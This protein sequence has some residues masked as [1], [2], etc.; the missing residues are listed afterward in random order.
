MNANNSGTNTNNAGTIS[1]TNAAGTGSITQ[2]FLLHPYSENVNPSAVEG[3]KLYLAATKELDE[4]KR[5][6]V[7]IENG[8]KVKNHLET[9]SS[10]CS[11]GF[12]ISKAPDSNRDTKDTIKNYKSITMDD[13][14]A[15]NNTR[16]GNGLNQ[17]LL[18][19]KIM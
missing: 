14:L 5:I 4:D 7:S 9:L 6:S 1:N 8:H 19:N 17:A 16:L 15:F 2:T 3:R 13:V 12:L 18:T 11:W 10:K